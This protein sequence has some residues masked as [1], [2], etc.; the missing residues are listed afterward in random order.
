[1]FIGAVRI[2]TA[3]DYRRLVASG[4][5]VM[6][7]RWP[8]DYLDGHLD[9]A[10][11]C[12]GGRFLWRHRL[13]GLLQGRPAVLIGRGPVDV[14]EIAEEM[15]H[16]GL[17]VVGMLTG[18]PGAWKARGLPVRSWRRL[19]RKDWELLNPRPPV[20]DVREP[21]EPHDDW[22]EGV[23]VPLS[24]WPSGIPEPARLANQA[25]VVGPRPR[26]AWAAVRLFEAGLTNVFCMPDA[27]E[28]DPREFRE[29]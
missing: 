7:L 6:D 10:L 13:A 5:V 19:Q 20:L 25:M 29:A 16:Q 12:S 3:E 14:G 17:E 2:V 18:T 11:S 4:A 15:E 23:S 27:G 8:L 22:P 28:I 21:D 1:M 26:V 24:T 9:G